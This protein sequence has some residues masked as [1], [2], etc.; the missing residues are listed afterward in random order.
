MIVVTQIGLEI[1]L[2]VFLKMGVSSGE[3][4]GAVYGPECCLGRHPYI[5]Y[6]LFLCL[7]PVYITL[8]GGLHIISCCWFDWNRAFT[9][10]CQYYIHY[11]TSTFL[12]FPFYVKQPHE[13]KPTK[14]LDRPVEIWK[15]QQHGSGP[16]RITAQFYRVEGE[17]KPIFSYPSRRTDIG[18]TNILNCQMKILPSDL[19][20]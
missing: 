20:I 5:Y 15:L 10:Y 17:K 18:T 3:L 1:D 9:M 12:C 8:Y 13:E 7:H 19:T 11:S 2:T 16:E 6:H 4:E 14:H